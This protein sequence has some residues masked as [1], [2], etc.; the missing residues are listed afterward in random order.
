VRALPACG[1]EWCATHGDRHGIGLVNR[2]IVTRPYANADG[3]LAK[4]CVNQNRPTQLVPKTLKR[5][6]DGPDRPVPGTWRPPSE[7]KPPRSPGSARGPASG[8]PAARWPRRGRTVRRGEVVQDRAVRPLVAAAGARQMLQRPRHTLQLG[9]AAAQIRDLLLRDRLHAGAR[10]IPVTPERQQVGDRVDAETEVAGATDE[11]QRVQIGLAVMAV[12][13]LGPR[14]RR[15][16]AG[17]LVPA[18]HLGRDAG[19]PRRLA[20]R[21]ERR[22]HAVLGVSAAASAG[23]G[24]PPARRS[25]SALPRTKT[26]ENAMAPAARIGDRAGPPNGTSTPAA[27]GISAAL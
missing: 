11:A 22:A 19:A 24:R 27:T 3:V 21:Q 20:D 16:Q 9:D 6:N 12:A 1:A 5:L 10:P 26:L 4:P 15:Q 25:R 2:R 14:G 18:D 8:E 7:E 13:G 17:R 23:V